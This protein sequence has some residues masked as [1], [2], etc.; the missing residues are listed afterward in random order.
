MFN[1]S[2]I[3]QER[4][5]ETI[6]LLYCYITWLCKEGMILREGVSRLEVLLGKE[7]LQKCVKVF[8]KF[9]TIIL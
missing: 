9:R 6:T 4:F 1:R 3:Y 2:A 5:R 7:L 8:P